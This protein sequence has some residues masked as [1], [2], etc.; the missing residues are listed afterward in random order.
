MSPIGNGHPD[1][2]AVAA[3]VE[4]SR[5]VA[6]LGAILAA[7]RSEVLEIAVADAQYRDMVLDQF[8]V[9]GSKRVIAY[10]TGSGFDSLPV[11]TSGTTV[12]GANAARLGGTI[13]N[14]GANA[15]ILYLCPTGRATAGAPAIWLAGNG[16]SWDFRLGNLTWC[17]SVTAVAQTGA[18]SL[19]VAEV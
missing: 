11:P 12:V 13:V 2:A 5:H 16:G 17:G 4:T 1:P 14:S 15:V 7:V 9:A 6:L 10:R 18:S 3:T 8:P 19:T